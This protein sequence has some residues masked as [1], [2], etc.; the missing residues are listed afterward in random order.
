LEVTNP[1]SRDGASSVTLGQVFQNR[2]FVKFYIGQVISYLGDRIDGVA[3][4]ALLV[5]VIAARMLPESEA[6]KEQ[7]SAKTLVT[8]VLLVPAVLLGPVIGTIVD[9]FDRR[10]LLIAM[11]IYRGIL[12]LA[13]TVGVDARTHVGVVY[14]AV[15]LVGVGTA[16]F[17]PA[18][19][20]F[21]TEIVPPEHLLRA[22]SISCMMGSLMTAV[23]TPI[24][25]ALVA[26][27]GYKWAL[28]ADAAT[29][30]FSMAS[31]LLIVMGAEATRRK[32]AREAV[33]AKDGSGPGAYVHELADG[34]RYILRHRSAG[35]AV[36]LTSVFYG[37]VGLVYGGLN[38]ITTRLAPHATGGTGADGARGA[39]IDAWV[40]GCLGVGMFAGGVLAGRIGATMRLRTLIGVSLTGA[41]G[42]FLVLGYPMSLELTCVAAFVT[43][44]FGGPTVVALE[45]VLQKAVPDVIRGRVFALNLLLLTVCL[46]VGMYA[47][48]VLGGL[49]Q[50]ADPV[51]LIAAILTM[52]AAVGFGG[53]LFAWWAYPAEVRI[54]TLT[55]E[56]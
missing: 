38:Q 2:N 24:G 37:M 46:L 16:V 21:I 35:V 19:T 55:P 6:L 56:V 44:V 50:I 36:T 7:G 26:G 33:L 18:K 43:G 42:M 12:L 40:F 30:F 10:K 20:A 17:S 47:T 39:A 29:Y 27:V 5:A 49:L 53:A 3:I 11:D 1:P 22:N 54:A 34:F 31:L 48:T 25:A 51:R 45:T 41:G 52:A 4:Q 28:V 13:V 14:G 23:G 9:R 15:F 32:E 8:I